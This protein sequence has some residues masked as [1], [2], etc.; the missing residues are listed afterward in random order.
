MGQASRA[1]VGAIGAC[2]IACRRALA[3][4]GVAAEVAAEV[5]DMVWRPEGRVR[6][7]YVHMPIY[8]NIGLDWDGA[9]Q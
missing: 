8:V 2:S 9:R 3:G 5:A 1:S 6:K 7:I 4:R